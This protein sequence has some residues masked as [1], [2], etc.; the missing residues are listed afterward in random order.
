MKLKTDFNMDS[1]FAL[2]ALSTL[3]PLT[4]AALK[5]KEPARPR[6]LAEPTARARPTTSAADDP[7]AFYGQSAGTFNA[8]VIPQWLA[9]LRH[10]PTQRNDPDRQ[11]PSARRAVRAS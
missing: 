9:T 6:F 4:K 10:R 5:S 8:K 11:T 7:P 1:A 2:Q 3:K